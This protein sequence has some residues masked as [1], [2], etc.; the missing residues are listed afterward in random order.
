MS[1]CAVLRRAA[2][3]ARAIAGGCAVA[4]ALG[5]ASAAHAAPEAG[6][7]PSSPTLEPLLRM[8]AAVVGIALCALGLATWARRRRI[9]KSGVDHRIDVLAMR[10]LG[11]RHRVALIEVGERRFLVGLSGD[12]IRPIAELDGGDFDRQLE[13]ALPEVAPPPVASDRSRGTSPVAEASPI[14]SGIGRFE[15]LDV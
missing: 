7:T 11:P 13:T 8:L 5:L 15:G 10:S 3:A 12:G 9:Q 2:P 14:G 4:V 1:G 6:S